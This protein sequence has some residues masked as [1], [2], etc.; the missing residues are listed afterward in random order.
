MAVAHRQIHRNSPRLAAAAAAAVMLINARWSL[1]QLSGQTGAHDPSS[2]I[3]DGSNYYYYATGQGI[4]SRTSTDMVNWS[5]APSVF[6]TPPAWTTQA[7]P[8]FT[9]QFWAP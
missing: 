1:G 9:G 4:A 6:S 2:L 7:V 8:S 3:K 5:A